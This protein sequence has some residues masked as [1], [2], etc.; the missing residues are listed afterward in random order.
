LVSHLLVKGT[1]ILM[2]LG[3]IQ[4]TEWVRSSFAERRRLLVRS[5]SAIDGCENTP[6]LEGTYKNA[7]RNRTIGAG[8]T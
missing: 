7:L 4:P 6:P 1:I 5:G 3:S 8:N 2:E